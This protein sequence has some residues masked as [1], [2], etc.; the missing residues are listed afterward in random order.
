MF[1]ESILTIVYPARVLAYPGPILAALDK[2]RA[3]GVG[4]LSFAMVGDSTIAA[5]LTFYLWRSRTGFRKSDG[6]ITRLI[7]LTVS[8]GALTSAVVAA[9]MLAYVISPNE[10]YV[11]FFNYPIG[12][13]YLNV[14]LTTLNIRGTLATPPGQSTTKGINSIPLTNIGA[15][16][17]PDARMDVKVDRVIEVGQYVGGKPR[18][19]FH[20]SIVL[21]TSMGDSSDGADGEV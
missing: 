7:V 17:S 4:S 5:T 20:E 10:L 13:M 6:L 9:D 12:K 15:Q 2:F 14:L 11:L 18:A 21:S 19:E 8:T 3:L 1:V 16:Q